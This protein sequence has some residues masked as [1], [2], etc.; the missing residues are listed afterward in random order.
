MACYVY[1]LGS[2]RRTGYRTYIGWT[3]KLDQRLALR[4]VGADARP[5][6]GSSVC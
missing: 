4:G 2:A 1:V 5:I 3:M 6:L